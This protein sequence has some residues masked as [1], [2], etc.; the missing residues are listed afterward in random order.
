M[1]AGTPKKKHRVG[2]NVVTKCL[3]MTSQQS[4]QTLQII[5]V[6]NKEKRFDLEN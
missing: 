3:K 2:F 1:V 4:Y 6:D 5:S